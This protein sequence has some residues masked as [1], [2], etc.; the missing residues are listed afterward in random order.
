MKVCIPSWVRDGEVSLEDPLDSDIGP[1]ISC[2]S[3]GGSRKPGTASTWMSSLSNTLDVLS[4]AC[5]SSRKS[6]NAGGTDSS[7]HGYRMGGMGVPAN[8]PNVAQPCLHLLPYKHQECQP[9]TSLVFLQSLLDISGQEYCE[10]SH[11]N[12]RNRS[13][14]TLNESVVYKEFQ[15]RGRGRIKKCNYVAELATWSRQYYSSANL[16]TNTTLKPGKLA[17]LLESVD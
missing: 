17:S 8:R 16:K 3:I 14:E 4:Q 1:Y 9:R 6:G 10:H 2:S 12:K 11:L 5:V 13:L 7:S 15:C